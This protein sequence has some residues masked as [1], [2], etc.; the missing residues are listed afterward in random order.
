MPSPPNQHHQNNPQGHASKPRSNPPIAPPVQNPAHDST[1]MRRAPPLHRPNP[2]INPSATSP[3][4]W[5]S[6]LQ[7]AHPITYQPIT[8]SWGLSQDHGRTGATQKGLTPMARWAGERVGEQAW[9]RVE[10]IYVE[11]GA[12]SSSDG[13]GGVERGDKSDS[14]VRAVRGSVV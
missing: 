13:R 4:P 9:N 14:S 11:R 1:P 3:R 5:A 2:S 7:N 12:R 10:G 8:R 6:S